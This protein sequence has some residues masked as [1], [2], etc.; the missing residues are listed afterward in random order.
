MRSHKPPTHV[1]VVHMLLAP[2]SALVVHS[3]V[4]VAVWVA[5]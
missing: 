2:Q 3:G 4:A 5:V 1:N